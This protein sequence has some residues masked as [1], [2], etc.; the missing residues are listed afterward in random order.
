[1]LN[2]S[3]SLQFIKELFQQ[4]GNMNEDTKLMIT[5]KAESYIN[6]AE[7]IKKLLL[8]EG[9]KKKAVAEGG[10]GGNKKH[11]EDDDEV[12]TEN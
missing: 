10:G 7:Q 1:M 8:S 5:K 12:D 3:S 6:R 2:T 4:N 9:S 11:G